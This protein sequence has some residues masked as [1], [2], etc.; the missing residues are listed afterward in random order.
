MDSSEKVKI[1]IFNDTDLTISDNV[2][3]SLSDSF[4]VATGR[5][6]NKLRL[7]TQFD[8]FYDKWKKYAKNNGLTEFQALEIRAKLFVNFSELIGYKYNR[9]KR[10]ILNN[11]FE[12]NPQILI[13]P[14]D[15]TKS[16]TLT[17]K[18]KYI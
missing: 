15:K 8:Y 9:P 7:L 13:I 1:E 11:F 12:K 4:K 18:T 5:V 16:V 10:T 2:L 6:P 3:E 17:D 14:S